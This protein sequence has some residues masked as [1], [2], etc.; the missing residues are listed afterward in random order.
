MRS[1]VV[2]VPP[3]QLAR[4]DSLLVPKDPPHTGKRAEHCARHSILDH[5]GWDYLEVESSVHQWRNQLGRRREV[6]TSA[7]IPLEQSRFPKHDGCILMCM[8][9]LHRHGFL[10]KR[11]AAVLVWLVAIVG[12]Y[13]TISCRGH[14]SVNVVLAFWSRY[15]IPE[16]YFSRSDGR[17]RGP[18]SR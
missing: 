16:W 15:F 14:Y 11:V 3:S 5:P 7:N 9:V 13:F 10:K 2:S 1:Y 17:V 12:I 4:R 6:D 18:V 8:A